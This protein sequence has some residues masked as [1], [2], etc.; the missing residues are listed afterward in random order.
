MADAR[1][2]DVAGKVRAGEEL[3][4]PRV[5][6]WLKQ[7]VPGLEGSPE[8]TQYA[9]GASNW[10][11]RLKYPTRDFILR[12]PPAGTKAKSAHDMGRE[13]RVQKAL[14]PYFSAVPAMVGL[15]Q[16]E[17]VLGAEFYVMERLEGI[18]PR[19]KMRQGFGLTPAE[20][21]TLCTHVLDKLLELHQVDYQ[22]AGLASLGKGAGYCKRQ[23]EGWTDPIRRRAPGTCRAFV[24][25][26]I[27]CGSRRRATWPLA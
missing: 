14:K 16:D 8:I 15:C 13:Y 19:A 21:R 27:G 9:G 3:D 4:A 22:A 25:C 11:Y 23:V 2:I 26:A 6:A 12:R 24:M 7:Q 5:D 20:N 17:S 18:I 10:T 1:Q